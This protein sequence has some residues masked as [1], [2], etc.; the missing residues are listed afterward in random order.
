MREFRRKV[1]GFLMKEGET[2]KP[3]FF[4]KEGP[5]RSAQAEDLSLLLPDKPEGDHRFDGEGD[6]AGSP[7]R[8]W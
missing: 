2:K 8:A 3:L 1:P 4:K 7:P 5:V 6:P